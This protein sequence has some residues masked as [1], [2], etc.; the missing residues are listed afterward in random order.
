[1]RIEALLTIGY[2]CSRCWPLL[3]FAYTVQQHTN[4]WYITYIAVPCW[5]CR[6]VINS[7]LAL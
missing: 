2:V 4:K 3:L 7:L 1:M 5:D 6:H